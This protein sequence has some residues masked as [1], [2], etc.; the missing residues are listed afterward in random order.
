MDWF[1]ENTIKKLEVLLRLK[2][3]GIENRSSNDRQR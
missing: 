2:N 1:K 3:T